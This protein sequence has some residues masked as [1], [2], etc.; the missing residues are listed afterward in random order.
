MYIFWNKQPYGELRL[1]SM[2]DFFHYQL[3]SIL[4]TKVDRILDENQTYDPTI[5]FGKG[6]LVHNLL[7]FSVENGL[8]TLPILVSALPVVPLTN[9][10]RNQLHSILNVK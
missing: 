3:M 1:Y 4:T 6:K 7:Q 2:V 8:H 10:T 5:N 9:T